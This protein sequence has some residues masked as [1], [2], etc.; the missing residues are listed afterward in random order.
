[1]VGVLKDKDWKGI[2]AAWIPVSGAFFVATPPGERALEAWVAKD[3]LK[4][5]GAQVRKMGSLPQA[6]S[7]ARR[8]A[9]PQGLVVAAGSLYSV[10]EL[11]KKRRIR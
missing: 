4:A 1:V 6:L 7:A 11:L 10:G 3:W 8:W 5:K 2:L 9:G